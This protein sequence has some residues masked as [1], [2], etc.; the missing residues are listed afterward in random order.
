M[1]Q[2]L[3]YTLTAALA[4]FPFLFFYFGSRLLLKPQTKSRCKIN[5]MGRN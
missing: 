2:F 3:F 4:L 1:W 5:S